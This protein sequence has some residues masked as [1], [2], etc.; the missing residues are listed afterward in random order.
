MMF[1]GIYKLLKIN[2]P[3]KKKCFVGQ[4]LTS[5]SVAVRM[6]DCSLHVFT[7]FCCTVLTIKVNVAVLNKTCNV[8]S[9]NNFFDFFSGNVSNNI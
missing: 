2:K 6:T 1:N 9:S 3:K 4:T 7:L 8:I 5:Y